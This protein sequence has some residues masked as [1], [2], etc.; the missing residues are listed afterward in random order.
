MEKEPHKIRTSLLERWSVMN[1]MLNLTLKIWRQASRD[2]QGQPERSSRVLAMV[3]K[4]DE[5]GFGACTN[6]SECE[7]A[8]P[9]GIS[10]S[11]IARLN[12]EYIRAMF[13]AE[14]S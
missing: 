8:C 6:T 14:S 7:A 11:N 4:M 10:V 9:K 2:S 3:A 13:L 12:Y 5:E 1:R